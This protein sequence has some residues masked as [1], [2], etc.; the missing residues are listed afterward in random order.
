MTDVFISYSRKDS[1]FGRQLYQALIA[2][3]RTVWMD[4]SDIPQ[5]SEWWEEITKGIEQCHN[6]VFLLSEDSVAS[7]VCNLEIEHARNNN[8]RI[9]PVLVRETDVK[10][11]HVALIHQELSEFQDTLYQGRDILAIARDNWQKLGGVNWFNFTNEA[12]FDTRINDLL[13]A[14][15]V[16]IDYIHEHTRLL[17]RAKDWEAHK[18]PP[19]LLLVNEDLLEAEGWLSTSL[20]ENK[21]PLPTDLQK[22]YIHESHLEHTRVTT[23]TRRIVIEKERLTLRQLLSLRFIGAFLGC[24]ISF[25]YLIYYQYALNDPQGWF[26]YQST[27]TGISVGAVLGLGFGLVIVL[28]TE[29]RILLGN[30]RWYLGWLASILLCVLVYTGYGL[31]D[32][33]VAPVI[34]MLLTALC[35]TSGFALSSLRSFH[36]VVRAAASTLGI[37]LAFYL[38]SVLSN[39]PPLLNLTGISFFLIFSLAILIG[40]LT[41]LPEFF[42]LRKHINELINLSPKKGVLS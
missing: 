7:P 41:F 35:F 3:N 19:S 28:A 9:V 36:K 40:F 34:T 24:W 30:K 8:R 33:P 37:L 16:D 32:A 6:F 22:L 5:T 25:G 11:A 1:K 23:E 10:K 27:I 15:D 21:H 20:A 2:H 17:I 42:G 13:N 26:I 38:P 14:L 29:G 31:W 18:N 4:W 12:D 39:A